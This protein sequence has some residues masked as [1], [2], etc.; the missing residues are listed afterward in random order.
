[1]YIRPPPLRLRSLPSCSHHLQYYAWNLTPYLPKYALSPCD[2]P[3]TAPL[4]VISVH[5]QKQWIISVHLPNWLSDC[6]PELPPILTDCP[7]YRR[8]GAHRVCSGWMVVLGSGGGEHHG[9]K[10]IPPSKWY[11]KVSS[12]LYVCPPPIFICPSVSQQLHYKQ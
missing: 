10:Q 3:P 12:S 4:V 8:L 1:M 9:R 7:T 11:W 6:L 5:H 2:A